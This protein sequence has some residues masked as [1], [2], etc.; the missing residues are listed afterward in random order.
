ME[1]PMKK[2]KI[3]QTDSIKELAEFWDTHDLTDFE[4][5]LD[6]V[7]EPVIRAPAITLHLKPKEAKIVKDLARTRGVEDSEL[8]HQWIREKIRAA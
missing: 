6:L 5:Q 4:D 7:D 1:H 3:P 8:I 2:P